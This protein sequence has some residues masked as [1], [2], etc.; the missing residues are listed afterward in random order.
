MGCCGGN[1]A[2]DLIEDPNNENENEGM[3]LNDLNDELNQNV[4]YKYKSRSNRNKNRR[5]IKQRKR[6]EYPYII[7]NKGSYIELII[8]ADCFYKENNLPIYVK[9]GKYVK[10]KVNGKWKI[11][12][13][14]EY[15]SSI[16]IPSSNSL[17]FNYGAL[18]GRIGS[19]EPFLVK[20]E[21]VQKAENSGTLYLR[22]N[23][24][25]N[26]KVEPVGSLNINIYDAEFLSVEEINKKIG[27]KESIIE[28]DDVQQSEIEYNLIT[29][30]NN[31]RL[32]PILFYEKNIED[33]KN[34][35]KTKDYLYNFKNEKF[36]N[37]SVHQRATKK[38]NS[39]CELFNNNK[40][41]SKQNVISEVEKIEKNIYY[42]L[43]NLLGSSRYVL[44]AKIGKKYNALEMCLLFLFDEEFR[45][46]IFNIQYTKIAVKIIKDFFNESHVIIV[47]LIQDI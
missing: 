10:F 35:I 25:K 1:R 19:C 38:I 8:F 5:P 45:E 39:Y 14:F 37:L 32:N 15:C 31:L 40:T 36:K 18:V 27:W 47:C 2:T 46:Y 7:K 28:K 20:D 43:G 3:I 26:M 30:I 4:Y 23:L 6:G 12:S 13:K 44:N 42:Y 21:L 22:M 33:Y 16:G 17:N 41:I 9:K 34:M 29:H 24:P 11:D